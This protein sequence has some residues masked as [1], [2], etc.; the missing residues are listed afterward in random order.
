MIIHQALGAAAVIAA[1]T[2]YCLLPIT[3]A[4]SESV[5][6]NRAPAAQTVRRSN[7]IWVAEFE[8][9]LQAIPLP[10]IVD[11]ASG[12]THAPDINRFYVVVNN[13]QLLIELDAN[14]EYQREIQLQGFED[15]EGVAYAGPGKLAIIDERLQTVSIAN[16]QEDTRVLHRKDLESYSLHN[17]PETN[18][19]FEGVAIDPSKQHLYLA[20]EE[21]PEA[22]F[23]LSEANQAPAHE[24][25]IALQDDHLEDLAGLHFDGKSTN[26]LVLSDES[27]QLREVNRNGHTI[28]TLSLGAGIGGLLADI[29][30]PEGITMDTEGA[31][32]IVS[33]PN[34]IYRFKRTL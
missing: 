15:T 28:S 27:R 9:D 6:D 25:N 12:I 2:C 33:E 1:S 4:I 32:Y 22:L 20:R 7:D 3:A 13:P 17:G 5:W 11:N 16:I 26:L 30:Q 34:L 21:Q 31:L 8:A 23:R 24:G 19:G 14:L 10:G 18:Q 29:P